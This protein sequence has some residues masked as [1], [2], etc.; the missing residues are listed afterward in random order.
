MVTCCE[1]AGE[2]T[3]KQEKLLV[4]KSKLEKKEMEVLKVL[5]DSRR[6]LSKTVEKTSSSL[7][8][9]HQLLAER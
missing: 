6:N 8:I 1:I 4:D 3:N 2:T 5:S 7:A 9:F